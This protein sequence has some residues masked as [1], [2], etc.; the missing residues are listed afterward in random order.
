M[1]LIV[2]ALVPLLFATAFWKADVSDGDM[3]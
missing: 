1:G 3:T 2:V